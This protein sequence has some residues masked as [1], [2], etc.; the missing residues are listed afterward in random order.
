[1]NDARPELPRRLRILVVED[2]PD[3][4]AL[5][6]RQLRQGGYEPEC[7]RVDT[8]ASMRAALASGEWDLVLSDYT[9]PGFTALDALALARADGRDIPFI[10][11]SGSVGEDTA[12]LAMRSG[13]HD[14]FAK[15]EL[16]R[17]V[18]AAERELRA[19]ARRREARQARL[20]LEQ[21]FEA[22]AN[23]APVLS[24]IADAFGRRT[25]FSRPWLEFRGRV[26]DAELGVGWKAGLHPDDAERYL[27]ELKDATGQQR[28]FRTELRLQRADGSYG[29]VLESA[30]PLF[31]GGQF[32]G[33]VGSA[34]DITQEKEARQSAEAASRMKDEFLATLSH[35]LRT[36]LNAI[37]GWAHLLQEPES[38]EETRR[39]ALRTIERNAR[40]QAHLVADMLDVSRIVTGKLHLNVGP[41]EVRQVIEAAVDALRP[42]L[43]AKDID[44][45]A[46]LEPEATFVHGDGERL[47]QVVWNLLSNAIKFSPPQ[48]AVRLRIRGA[49][50]ETVLEVEDEGA[51]I[52]MDFLPYVFDRFRQADSS[53]TRR[54]GGLG[55]GLAIVR[56]LVEAHGGSVQATN[57]TDRSGARLS[58]HLPQP[59]G[60][61]GAPA[62]VAAGE[63]AAPSLEG[64]S[65]LVVEDDADSLELIRAVL[66]RAGARV[67]T[68]TSAAAAFERLTRERPA[69][70]VSDIGMPGE[71]GHELIRKVRRLPPQEGGL[72][73]AAALTAFASSSDRIGLLEAGFQRHLP[74]PILPAQLVQAVADLAGLSRASLSA[75]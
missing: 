9:L 14:Y 19:A 59:R 67:A 71:S 42:A 3:D 6:E 60:A 46:V 21:R 63:D 1:M 13:A 10:V 61:A 56:H 51:G 2:S 24:W 16:R 5:L 50:R 73:P 66:E 69:V 35:E 30:T 52:P 65:V 15:S 68:A 48:G 57:C 39:K 49:A 31:E 25:W 55:L 12:V 54:H 22:L 45:E 43:E 32:S 58:V 62:G 37:L 74:K 72:T 28:P 53:S 75:R 7:H 36:P 26:P 64:V 20:E 8:A 34:I 17:L 33:H 18:A 47:Q 41:V 40:L 23:S 44:F 70:L 29:W 27:R 38:D 4:A 11:V